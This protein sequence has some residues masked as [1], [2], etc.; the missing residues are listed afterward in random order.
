MP[1]VESSGRPRVFATTEMRLI[2]HHASCP[3]CGSADVGTDQ[4][5]LGDGIE[6][7][8]YVCDHCGTAWPLAC[9]CEWNTAHAR[10]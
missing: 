8:A 6:E 3:E 10:R 4:V 9:I 7:T 2:P 5:D 1:S